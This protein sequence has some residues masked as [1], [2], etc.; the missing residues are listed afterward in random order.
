[1][2]ALFPEPQ[3]GWTVQST[4]NLDDFSGTLQT[5][6][7]AERV[8]SDGPRLEDAH[9]TL[10]VA[11]WKPG[12]APV[13]LVDAHTP[14]ACWPGTGWEPEPVPTAQA[15]LAIDGRRL[16]PAECRLFTLNSFE[17]HVWFWHLYGGRPLAYVDP[18]SAL[19]LVRQ[20]LRYGFGQPQD[21]L[22]VRVSSNRPWREIATQPTLRQFFSNVKPLG[23]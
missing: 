1:L 6:D 16:A 23:L 22:F 4:P 12:Q 5:H 17:T 3:P 18:Y 8:Y 9:L 21:Q 13:T 19:R 15:V 20:A 14:D 11:Y 10:Y 2:A 7:L